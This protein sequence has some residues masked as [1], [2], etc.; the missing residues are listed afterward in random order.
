LEE[1]PPVK[2]QSPEIAISVSC[3]DLK[4]QFDRPAGATKEN[5]K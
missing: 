4:V 3:G 5:T 1:D 2:V